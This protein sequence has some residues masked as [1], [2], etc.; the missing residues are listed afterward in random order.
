MYDAPPMRLAVLIALLACA[1]PPGK[2]PPPDGGTDAGTDA[3]QQVES[4]PPAGCDG[5]TRAAVLADA[6]VTAGTAVDRVLL[7]G[8]VVTPDVVLSPGDVLVVND[9]IACVAADCSGDPQAA[10]APIVDT[11]GVIFPGLVD[12]HNHTQYDYLRPWMPPHLFQNRGQWAAISEYKTA[13]STVNDFETAHVCDQVK[14]G[15]VRAMV[16]GTTTIQGTFNSNRKCFRTLVHNAEYGNEL[17]P[18]KMRTNITG[19]DSISATDAATIRADLQS[20]ALTAFVLHLAEGIDDTSRNELTTLESKGLLL[21]GTVIIHGTAL[22]ATQL[23]R[24]AAAGAKLVWSP[25]SNL[26]LYGATT[27][28]PTALA[29]GIP[30]SLAPDW[31]PTGSSTLLGEM[32]FA[33]SYSCKNWNGLLT[34]QDLVK[35]STS[36]PADQ[37]GLGGVVGRI[38]NGLLGDLLVI[39]DRGEDPYDTLVNAT[40]ADVRLVMISGSLRYGDASAMAATRRSFCDPV[41]ICSTSKVLC[42]P[43]TTD[44][45]DQLNQTFSDIRTDV[46]SFYPDPFTI[47]TSCN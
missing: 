14:Y 34:T 46:A 42:V 24:V 19:V 22:N 3:G 29:D 20:G 12:A 41:S 8:R 47:E 31:T 15:E 43:D 10:G 26:I 18:D 1:P 27:D 28:I 6:T 4:N 39:A 2:K 17:G 9:K 36:I 13:V 35:M 5:G 32:K 37:L 25:A 21:S 7:R 23:G 38:A 40:L 30:V 16:A 45:T 11:H 33:R 44:A